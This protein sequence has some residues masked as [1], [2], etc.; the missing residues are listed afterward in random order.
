MA[1]D[2]R[3]PSSK[4]YLDNAI[5]NIENYWWFYRLRYNRQDLEPRTVFFG[6]R[7]VDLGQVPSGSLMIGLVK[8][9]WQQEQ[10][11]NGA[12]KLVK[13]IEDLDGQKT[14]VVLQRG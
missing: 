5:E 13:A 3:Q 8:D 10:V 6:S 7:G 14:F 9:P 12:L 1:R 11:R 4:V 2:D